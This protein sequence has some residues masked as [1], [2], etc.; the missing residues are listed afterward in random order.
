[1]KYETINLDTFPRRK[2]FEYFSSMAFPYVGITADADITEMRNAQ[3][4]KGLPFFLSILYATGKAVKAVPELM[5]RIMDRNI[6]MLDEVITSHTVALED[7]S[8]AYA[9][10]RHGTALP[11]FLTEGNKATEEALK[12]KSLEDSNPIELVFVS[13]LPWVSFSSLIQPVPLSPP[14]S[15]PR[16]TFGRYREEHG[17]I[18][19]PVSL[20]ANHA[21]VDGIHIS[22]FFKAFEEA[23]AETAEEISG[24]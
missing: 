17:R 13:S 4:E 8:Y 10:I 18:L 24:L 9:E 12:S 5:M 14:D 1:M 15:N 16:I 7:G 21:L 3:K 6:I 11:Q 2:H 22:A 23:I 19:L 20:L